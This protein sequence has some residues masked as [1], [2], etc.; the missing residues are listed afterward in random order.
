MHRSLSLAVLLALLAPQARGHSGETE[1]P[2]PPPPPELRGGVPPAPRSGGAPGTGGGDDGGG[3]TTGGGTDVGGGPGKAPATGGGDDGSGPTTGG[4]RQPPSNGAPPGG[5]PMSRSGRRRAPGGTDSPAQWTYWWFAN[6]RDVCDWRTRA[7]ERSGA[8]TPGARAGRSELFREEV[9]LALTEALGDKSEDIANSAAIALGKDG[10][11]TSAPALLAV[12]RDRKRQ[13]SVRE[14]AALALGLLRDAPGASS[15]EV[16][17]TLEEMAAG[18]RESER[19][20][21]MSLYA[22]GLRGATAS[23]PLLIDVAERKSASGDVPAAAVSALGLGGHELTTP[24]LISYLESTKRRRGNDSLR[25]VYAAHALAKSGATEALPVLRDATRDKSA[26]VRR[27]AVLALAVLGDA[28]DDDTADA[29][30]RVLARDK[31][32]SVQHAAALSLGR[33]GHD[34]AEIALTRAFKKGS[35]RL[36]PFAALGLG[37]LARHPGHEGAALPLVR[38]LERISSA[39][40][41]AP[42][43]I[44]C[45]IAREARAVPELLKI[46][47]DGGDPQLRSHAALALGLI[48]DINAVPPLRDVLANE[49]DP[50][51]R[52]ESALALGMLGDVQATRAL[53]EQIEGGASLFLTSSAAVAIGRIGG[54]ESGRTLLTLLKNQKR[55]ALARAMAAVGLGLLLDDSDGRRLSV[56][57]ADLD[58]Y[59]LTPTVHLILRIV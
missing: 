4:P 5:Q 37:L 24:E 30:I 34:R 13:G 11:P 2:P 42:L 55:P 9:R 53:R 39:E 15:E 57:G 6:R 10:D 43:A 16:R 31:N 45:G 36:V 32:D 1:P 26:D 50:G 8:V 59:Q 51:L 35:S 29:L 18:K 28:Q 33:L 41:R 23:A 56:I 49:N 20:R 19:L 40:G 14:A 47:T 21:A 44:A 54:D 12:V 46:V 48:G 27:A 22:L 38:D 25:R 58:W 17:R 52:K 3:P 7:A